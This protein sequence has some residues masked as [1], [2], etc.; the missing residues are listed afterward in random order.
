MSE[1][2]LRYRLR[3]RGLLVSTD[4]GRKML[5]VR[6][7]LEGCP[8]QVLHLKAGDLVGAEARPRW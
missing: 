8:R 7:T 3:E 2:T 6:R 4:A 5:T 1:Q